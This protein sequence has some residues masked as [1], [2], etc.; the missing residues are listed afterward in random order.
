MRQKLYCYPSLHSVFGSISSYEVAE[1]VR[2]GDQRRDIKYIVCYNE[3]ECDF[4]CVCRLFEFRGI[5]C[6]H[7]LA[8]LT[9]RKVTTVPS[10]YVLTRWRKY[11]RRKHTYVTSNWDGLKP[12]ALR[13]DKMCNKFF[14]IAELGAESEDKCVVILNGLD[15]LMERVSKGEAV[16]ASSQPPVDV[17]Q[18]LPSLGQSR[19]LSLVAV[20]S[21]GR[22]PFK[23]KVSKVDEAVRK[24][25]EGR[26]KPRQKKL[27]SRD[28]ATSLRGNELGTQDS[29]N[30]GPYLHGYEDQ[31]NPTTFWPAQ[32]SAECFLGS[33]HH[34]AGV[35]NQHHFAFYSQP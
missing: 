25:K 31:V 23:R 6:R 35:D 3:V 32:L 14:D 26:H 7:L 16:C 28:L 19:V 8:V 9:Q 21:K 27:D 29:V 2:F 15:E 22:P 33:Q 11:V 17:S 5:L 18:T 1:D 20:R 4:Q 24:K 13:F 34:F 10:K 30:I 12:G